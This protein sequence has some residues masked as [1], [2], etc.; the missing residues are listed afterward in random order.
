MVINHIY[1]QECY[2]SNGSKTAK[3]I[4]NQEQPVK[5]THC[6]IVED[7]S[8]NTYSQEELDLLARLIYAEAGS[9][10]IT[11]EH[12]LVVGSVVLNRVKDERFPDDLHS[13]IYQNS[14]TVQ[15]ACTVNGMIYNE[16]D[17][18]TIDNAKYLLTYG[19]TIPENIVWQSQMPQ[20]NGIWKEIQGHYFCY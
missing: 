15:Y 10:W 6:G 20:G 4:D 7:I 3:I 13:V 14:P 19:S 1:C 9:K 18:R 16:P 8:T 11:D 5:V 2:P 12:Q 17:K